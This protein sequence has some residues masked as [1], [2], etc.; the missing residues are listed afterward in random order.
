MDLRWGYSIDKFMGQ[1][2]YSIDKFMG[3]GLEMEGEGLLFPY[4]LCYCWSFVTRR[5]ENANFR[6]L[7]F[8]SYVYPMLPVSLDCSFL[9]APSVFS[10][11]YLHIYIIMEQPFLRLLI[12][13]SILS[14]I[15]LF[16]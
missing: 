1:W 3:L 8:L 2:V 14:I 7:F 4:I 5:E 10:N 6:E 11:V 15:N 9:I 12:N 16:I 13:T